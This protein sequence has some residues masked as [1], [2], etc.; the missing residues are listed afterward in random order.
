VHFDLPKWA[1]VEALLARGDRRVGLFLEHLVTDG[2]SWAQVLK[3]VPF[4]ADFWVMRERGREERFPW[5]ILDHGIDRNFLWDE[6]QRALKGLPSP[7]CQ[8]EVCRRCGICR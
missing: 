1:Y 2:I 8:P 6:Y 7:P 4:N 3:S 5:E